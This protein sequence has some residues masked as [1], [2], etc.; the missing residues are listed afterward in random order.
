VLTFVT[1]RAGPVRVQIFDI[2]GRL[3]RTLH[4]RTW[5]PAGYHP[6]PIDGRTGDGARMPS[7]IYLYRV[8]SAEGEVT[9]RLAVVR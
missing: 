4:D 6:V 2:R 9:G 3:V 7:G 1:S 8:E 5:I